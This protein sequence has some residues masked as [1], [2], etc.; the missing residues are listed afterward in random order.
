MV[1]SHSRDE[2]LQPA[3]PQP[4]RSFSSSFDAETQRLG[5]APAFATTS[6]KGGVGKT[7]VVANLAAALMLKKKQIMVIDANLGLANLDLFFGVKPKY[8]LADF[9]SAAVSLSEII[10]INR[11][12]ILLV[13]GASG[14]PNIPALPPHQNPPP[15]PALAPST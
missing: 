2:S 11:H 7:N 10:T 8:T 13:P 6:G 9:F 14:V 4:F 3:V 12:G 1:E 15:P 5:A